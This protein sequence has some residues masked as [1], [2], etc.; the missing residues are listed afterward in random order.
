MNQR[1]QSMSRAERM[2]KILSEALAP[3]ELEVKDD[4][5][6]HAGHLS[7]SGIS[8]DAKETHFKIKIVSEAFEKMSRIDRQ[9]KVNDLLKDEFLQG[10][11]AL[12]MICSAPSEA[13]LQK[14]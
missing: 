4:S 1:S 9:R 3:T 8:P 14:K 12:S 6:R 7:E 13:K 2:K 10:L 11:H 5:Q